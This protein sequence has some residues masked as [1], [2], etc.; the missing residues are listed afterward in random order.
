MSDQCSSIRII[1]HLNYWII[2][3]I[4]ILIVWLMTLTTPISTANIAYIIKIDGDKGTGNDFYVFS[5]RNC[6][7]PTVIKKG[8]SGKKKH[9]KRGKIIIVEHECRSDGYKHRYKN[10]HH[11]P[12]P[13]IIHKNILHKIPVFVP[14]YTARMLSKLYYR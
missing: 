13:I 1:S 3:L 12:S 5:G 10:H 6:H 11:Y 8:H 2:L 7:T 14:F 4:F 9:L